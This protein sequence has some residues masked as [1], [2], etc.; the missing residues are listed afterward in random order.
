M[1]FFVALGGAC[2]DL[3]CASSALSGSCFCVC[4]RMQVMKLNYT[5]NGLEFGLLLSSH[6]D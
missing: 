3:R 4:T 6:S 5:S 1:S 2:H